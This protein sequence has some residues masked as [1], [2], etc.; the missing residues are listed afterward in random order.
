MP[1]AI[2]RLIIPPIYRLWIRKV[3]GVENIP[4]DKAFIVAS[5]HT[6]YFDDMLLPSIIMTKIDK[7][8][9]ALVNSYYWKNPI[10]GFFLSLWECIPAY[11]ENEEGAK[12]KNRKS[13]QKAVSYLKNNEIMMIL[14]EGRRSRDGRL[15]KG[16]T[17][18]AKIALKAKVPVLPCGAIG[19]NNILPK[20]KFF[21]RFARCEVKIG[22]PMHF[23]KYYGKKLNNKI[24]EEVTR[25]IMEEIAKL[26]GQDYN[27]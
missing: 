1:H 8:I 19:V 16:Y 22:K 24:L 2:S 10:T 6:S 12:K 21:P 3:E 18:I 13:I 4:K 23:D 14:P 9:H 27:Y 11:V 7:Q 25:S 26:V 20:G 15:Q 17:G 5:N